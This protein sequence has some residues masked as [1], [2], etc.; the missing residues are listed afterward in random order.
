MLK[1]SIIKKQENRKVA[2]T[3]QPNLTKQLE[4]IL[5]GKEEDRSRRLRH[6]LWVFRSWLNA[7]WKLG[8]P[9]GIQNTLHLL[10]LLN[11]I[12]YSLRCSVVYHNTTHS[13]CNLSD[14][15]CVLHEATLESLALLRSW[16]LRQTKL[17]MEAPNSS[18]LLVT[19]AMPLP[20]KSQKDKNPKKNPKPENIT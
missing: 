3:A 1:A 10:N 17:Q 9:S 7:Y 6:R 18:L 8:T 15:Y 19:S 13:L 4:K 20:L 11:L 12:T 16:L 14:I 5:S 2:K